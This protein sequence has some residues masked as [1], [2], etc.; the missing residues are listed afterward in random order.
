M[1]HDLGNTMDTLHLPLSTPGIVSRSKECSRSVLNIVHLGFNALLPAYL[2]QRQIKGGSLQC[3]RASPTSFLD[4]LRGVSSLIVYVSHFSDPYQPG[5][6]FS[7][8]YDNHQCLLQLPILRL[9]YSGVPMVA[10]FFVI[11][12]YVLSYKPAMLIREGSWDQ[13]HDT[14]ASSVFRRGM[15]IF[16]PALV[17][18][19][20]VMLAVWLRVE[21]FPGYLDLPGIIEP[22]PKQFQNLMMQL[23]DWLHFVVAELTNP[24]VWRVTDYPY[25]SHLWTIPIEF[26]TSM[27]LFLVILGLSKTRVAVRFGISSLLFAYCMW[28]GKWHVGLFIAGMCIAET[29]LRRPNRGTKWQL[30]LLWSAL[31]ALALFLLSFPIRN[32]GETPGYISLS[33]ISSRDTSW[34]SIGAILFVWSICSMPSLQ[35]IFTTPFALYLGKISYALYIIH[36][37][38][39]HSFGYEVVPALWKILGMDSAFR[40]Q[41]GFVLGFIIVTPVIFWVRMCSRD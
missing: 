6:K 30:S 19:W 8:G 27:I 21:D 5:K 9:T 10:I 4:G 41:L 7:Y 23:V 18:T 34:H 13:L 26:R 28:C 17:S 16:L 22:R 32:G 38:V 20:T 2:Y 12:G 35:K 14:L 31:F 36:G 40:Y 24:W 25:D 1:L 29:Q 15:R 11:S 37:P 33:A 39:L 3:E